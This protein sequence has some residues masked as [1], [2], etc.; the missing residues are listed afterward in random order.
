MNASGKPRGPVVVEPRRVIARVEVGPMGRDMRY[1]VTNLEGGRGK[2]LYEKSCSGRGQAG[3]HI[4]SWKAHLAADRMS[5]SK[6]NANQMRLMLHGCAYWNWWKLRD[7]GP[8]RPGGLGPITKPLA[9]RT[10]TN[11]V[12][13]RLSVAPSGKSPAGSARSFRPCR[14]T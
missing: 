12:D 13:I 2:H 8:E 7:N 10:Q 9:S 14:D 1:I 4:K 5:C 11:Q 6:A 3:N